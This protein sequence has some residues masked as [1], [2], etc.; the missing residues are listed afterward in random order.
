MPV[1]W[2]FLYT[3]TGMVVGCLDHQQLIVTIGRVRTLGCLG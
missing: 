2:E 3:D 1:D